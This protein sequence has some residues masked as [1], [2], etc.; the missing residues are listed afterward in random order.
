MSQTGNPSAYDRALEIARSK[1]AVTGADL[2]RAGI[3]RQYLHRLLERGHLVRAGRG[4][5][6][7]W[8]ADVTE[9]HTLVEAARRVPRGVVCLLSALRFHELTTQ[10]PFEIWLAVERKAWAPT[11]DA[12]P[13]RIVRM[14]GRAFEEGVEAHE[15]EGVA[16]RVYG[17]A[18]TVADCFKYRNKLGV[19][20][21]V[22]ALRE[23][24]RSRAYD[25]D[26]LWRYAKVTRVSAVIRP[27]MEA[28]G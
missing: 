23:Y 8:G 21:A 27:Y 28:V 2:G 11:P 14:S 7:A 3:P 20:V 9:H 16:V 4:V 10:A 19:D 24:R 18:K 1:G 25:A 12:I 17:T 26:A 22:E 13:V 15:V 5:Y 6:V